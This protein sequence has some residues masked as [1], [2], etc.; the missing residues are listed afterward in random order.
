MK[1][2]LERVVI[3]QECGIRFLVMPSYFYLL[4]IYCCWCFYSGNLETLFHLAIG[5]LMIIVQV[6]ISPGCTRLN[7]GVSVKRL[8]LHCDCRGNSRGAGAARSS[9][10]A[11]LF[12]CKNLEP[13]EIPR[14]TTEVSTFLPMAFL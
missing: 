3:L 4:H 7:A 11:L 9:N 13:A 2:F 12:G 1:N 6:T 5:T 14:R 10:T 8:H